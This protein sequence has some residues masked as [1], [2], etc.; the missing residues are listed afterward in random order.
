M[1]VTLRDEVH[2]EVASAKIV[3][4]YADAGLWNAV[5]IPGMPC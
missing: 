1:L 2:R 3:S 4:Q 5:T